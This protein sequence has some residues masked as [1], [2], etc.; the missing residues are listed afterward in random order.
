MTQ[1]MTETYT[2]Q[3]AIGAPPETVYAAFT[4]AAALQRWLAEH[5]EVALDDGVFEF[6]GRFTLDGERGRQR[7]TSF[8]PGRGLSFSWSLGGATTE[9]AIAVEPIETVETVETVAGGAGGSVLTLTHSGVPPRSAGEAYWVRDLLMLSL[10]NLASYCE[11]REV[12]PMCDVS[13]SRDGQARAAVQIDA[14]PGQV[15]ASLIEPAQLDRW[16]ATGAEVEPHVG[17]RYSFGWNHGPVKIL[18]LEQDRA[19]AYSW[20]HSW[21]DGDGPDS[22]VVRWELE[23]SQGRT[24]LTIV[25][26][27]FGADRRPDGYQLGWQEFLVSLKRM[28]EVGP[29]WQP[30]RQIELATDN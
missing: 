24:Y 29:S 6:W 14:P 16:I 8:E 10:A 19:L 26:S 22:T 18:E 9:V 5:A 20:R 23:G 28:H 13:A 11:G 4:S 27:G 7:L 17:G 30:V 25:H 1:T 15:F 21:D 12:A 2:L 3:V